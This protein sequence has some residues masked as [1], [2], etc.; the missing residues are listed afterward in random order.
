[1]STSAP[2]PAPASPAKN[3][4]LL[5]D[6][7]FWERY[8][9]HNEAPLSGVSSTVIHLLIVAL[10]FG[11]FFI[12]N[13]FKVDEEHRSLPIEPIKFSSAGGG[14]S[15]HGS[16]TGPGAPG[17]S[18]DTLEGDAE[19]GLPEGDV[20]TKQKPPELQQLNPSKATQ[21]QSDFGDQLTKRP[22]TQLGSLA[23]LSDAA[24]KKLRQ[25][26]NPG[27]GSRGQGG[28]GQDGGRDTGKDTGEGSGTGKD[29]AGLN[30]RE[31]RVL[32]WTLLFNTRDGN[33]YLN[34]LS[35]LGAWVAVPVN[36]DKGQYKLIR[37][38]KKPEP[39]EE[40][41]SSLNRIFWI[42]D[43]P[44]SVRALFTA[45][46]QPAPRSFVAFFPIEIEQRMLRLEL[47]YTERRY[48]TRDE[49]KIQETRFDVIKDGDKYDIK[50]HEVYLN[51]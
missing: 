47:A 48:R 12:N 41:V 6:E 19:A 43:K 11:V 2:A 21:L 44:E 24:R 39:K 7:Q 25:S 36:E 10:I 16:G 46:G 4:A 26:V 15:K 29:K 3:P 14:G 50:V 23:D 22:T 20:N 37:N 28:S 38:L 31:R 32:R 5:P 27:G 45:M 9:P 13:L 30:P 8:S 17:D 49:N 51:R 42:D 1:M 35:G 33:D 18:G 40:D 34:Q